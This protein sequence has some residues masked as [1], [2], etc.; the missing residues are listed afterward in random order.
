M[1]AYDRF[2]LKLKQGKGTAMSYIKPHYEVPKN[3]DAIAAY[4]KGKE[5]GFEF[6]LMYAENINWHYIKGLDKLKDLEK[7]LESSD[8]PITQKK[9]RV[10]INVI[11]EKDYLN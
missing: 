4:M 7:E 6:A 10:I 3:I 11:E 2:I 9:I 1:D 5:T 8:D